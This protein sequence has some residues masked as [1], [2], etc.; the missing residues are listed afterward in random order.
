M[1]ASSVGPAPRTAAAFCAITLLQTR[2][3]CARRCVSPSSIVKVATQNKIDYH[4]T[5]IKYRLIPVTMLMFQF[6]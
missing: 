3:T 6:C 4:R 5:I 1:A 2:A